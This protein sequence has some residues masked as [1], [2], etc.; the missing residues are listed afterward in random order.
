LP[1]NAIT[2]KNLEG[3]NDYV[4]VTFAK[5][6]LRIP[7]KLARVS[8]HVDV[9]MI[10]IDLP[11][12]VP[13]LELNDN[14]DTIQPGHPIVVMGYPGVSPDVVGLVASKDPANTGVAARVVPDPTVSAGNIGRVI[15][16]QEAQGNKEEIISQMG[17]VY[18]LTVNSTGAGNS[19]GP[20][21]DDQG[22]VVGIFTYALHMDASITFAVPIRYGM[23]LMGT[24]K[25]L[26]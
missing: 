6:R 9:A 16:G 15:R 17:D 1:G 22:R 7:A 21:F 3:R 2:G 8:D 12:S 25:V 26:K 18:Q 24:T 4:D 19:G 13:K 14:Y 20:V 10:K 5:N 11:R 23:E